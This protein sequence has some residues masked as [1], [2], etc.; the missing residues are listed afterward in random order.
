VSVVLWNRLQRVRAE[1]EAPPR[2]PPVLPRI[3]C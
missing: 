1:L 3:G 2:P